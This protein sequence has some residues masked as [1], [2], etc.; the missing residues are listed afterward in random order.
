MLPDR[1][2][3]SD[4]EYQK[5]FRQQFIGQ[6]VTAIIESRNPVQ[7]RSA[8]YFMI[9]QSDLADPKIINE[10]LLTGTLIK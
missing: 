5:K 6:K 3:Y 2:N 8:R 1:L 9:R 7:G 10:T 4:I